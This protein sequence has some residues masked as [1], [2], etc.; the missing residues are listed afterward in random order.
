M[1]A[2]HSPTKN[3]ADLKGLFLALGRTSPNTPTSSLLLWF[4][5][6]VRKTRMGLPELFMMFYT[7]VETHQESR[8]V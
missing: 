8:G 1:T 3:E 2:C 6:L 4:P 5:G 7:S